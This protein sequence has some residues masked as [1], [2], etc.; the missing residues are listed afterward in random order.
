MTQQDNACLLSA[1]V[2]S[3]FTTK[4]FKWKTFKSEAKIPS[5]RASDSGFDIYTVENNVWLKPHQTHLFSTGLGCIIPKGYWLRA[6]DRGS[7]GS[8][9][10][11]THCGIIDEEYTGEIFI[12]LNNTNNYPILFTD[13]VEKVCFKRTWYGRKYM[14]YPTSKAICQVIPERRVLADSQ[15]ATDLEWTNAVRESDRGDSKLG[16]SGK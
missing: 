9:G 16:A 13:A 6:V 15:V 1:Q 10:I 4:I 14:C 7:T 5:K 12:A 2:G 8:K 11:H 3:L